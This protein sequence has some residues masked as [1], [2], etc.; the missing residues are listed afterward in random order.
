MS[1]WPIWNS[2]SSATWSIHIVGV[3]ETMRQ[4]DFLVIPIPTYPLSFPEM[5][6]LEN[7]SEKSG[8]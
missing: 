3:E 5:P 8:F 1:M 2:S 7:Y 4:R 6:M